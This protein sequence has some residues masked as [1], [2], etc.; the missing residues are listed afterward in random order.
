MQSLSITYKPD[1]SGCYWFVD[2]FDGG[3]KENRVMALIDNGYQC[4][5]W[6]EQTRPEHGHA[7]VYYKWELAG[8]DGDWYGLLREPRHTDADIKH[9]KAYI[10]NSFDA[11]RISVITTGPN[12]GGK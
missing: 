11:V 9:A 4:M 10:R 12:L 7:P 3:D 6:L 5:T 1:G 2:P 8:P